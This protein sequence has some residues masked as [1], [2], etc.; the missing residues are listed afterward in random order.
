MA[1]PGSDV[2]YPGWWGLYFGL[3][4]WVGDVLPMGYMGLLYGKY[5]I[6][7]SARYMVWFICSGCRG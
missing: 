7:M 5:M 2:K 6:G 1:V 3:E 4:T